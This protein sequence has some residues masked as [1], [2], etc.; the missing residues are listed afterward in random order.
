MA[1]SSDKKLLHQTVQ[2]LIGLV[3]LAAL[4][5]LC[6]WQARSIQLCF[7]AKARIESAF[8]SRGLEAA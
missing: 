4:T 5:W 8:T 6:A 2:I 1:P 7:S 3:A